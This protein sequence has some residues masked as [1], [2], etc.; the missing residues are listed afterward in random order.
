MSVAKLLIAFLFISGCF[1]KCSCDLSQESRLSQP[2]TGH[3]IKQEA[4]L[5]PNSPDVSESAI[6]IIYGYNI[7]ISR[8]QCSF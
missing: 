6:D 5:L 3:N 2:E 1:R 7:G 8:P 4:D